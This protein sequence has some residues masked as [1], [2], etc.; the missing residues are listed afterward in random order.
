[1]RSFYENNEKFRNYVDR[2]CVKHGV[3]VDA[4]LT[5]STV[6]NAYE[7]YQD[8]EKGKISVSEVKV[9]CGGAGAEMGECK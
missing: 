1:M 4:A 2:Y 7:Y 8:A 3:S 9:G 6:R 5:H